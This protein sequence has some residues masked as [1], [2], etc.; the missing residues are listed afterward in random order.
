MIAGTYLV[1]SKKT[2]AKYILRLEGVSPMLIIA[3]SF[4]LNAFSEKGGTTKQV[5]N[6]TLS[7]IRANMSDYEF[8][9]LYAEETLNLLEVQFESITL[10]AETRVKYNEIW[11]TYSSKNAVILAIMKDYKC[12]TQMARDFITRFELCQ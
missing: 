4:D 11:N 10:D 2:S 6:T 9:P 12:S 3:N 1:S 8:K 7:E 5:S